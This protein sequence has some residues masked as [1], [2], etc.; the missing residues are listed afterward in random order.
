LTE[1]ET[2][3]PN[4]TLK[5]YLVFTGYA[6]L[7]LVVWGGLVCLNSS[8]SNNTIFSEGK[9]IRSLAGFLAVYDLFLYKMIDNY[10]AYF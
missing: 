4:Y 6:G 8:T 3:K 9:T 7:D 5:E 10:I 1:K 2:E